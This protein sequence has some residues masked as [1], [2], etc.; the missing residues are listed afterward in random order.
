MGVEWYTMPRREVVDLIVLIPNRVTK[1]SVASEHLH[2]LLKACAWF[3]KKGARLLK[4]F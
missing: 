2:I 1:V 3:P 4:Y